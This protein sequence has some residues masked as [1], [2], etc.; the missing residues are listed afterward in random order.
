MMR[1]QKYLSAAGL[2]SRRKGETYILTGRVAVNG[3][4]VSQLGVQVDPDKD[5]VR[6]DGKPLQLNE[7]NIYIA[8]HK[9]VGVVSSCDHPDKKLVI[10]L[11]DVGARI[12]PVGRLDQDS[13]GLLLLTN[14]GALHHRLAHPKF[15]HEKEY[16]VTATGPMS[17]RALQQMRTGVLLDGK[18][19]QPAEVKRVAANRFRIIL[20]EGRNRQIRR[21]V[22]Q[23]GAKVKRLIR[24]RVAHIRLGDLMP[25]QWRYLTKHEKERL[26]EG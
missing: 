21:M 10:N 4:V 8:L 23:V 19:T 3:T 25:G 24:V 12:F 5:E 13:E 6:F 18:R 2:C 14:D 15:G 11:V 9:P 17:D 16:L 20:K 1:L 26:P 22:N 7:K